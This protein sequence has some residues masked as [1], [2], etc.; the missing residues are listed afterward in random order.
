MFLPERLAHTV[1]GVA[2][3]LGASSIQY[4]AANLEKA[5]AASSAAHEMELLCASL[6]TSIAQLLA[7]LKPLLPS[8]EDAPLQTAEWPQLDSVI[9]QLSR[10][11]A[12]SDSRAV[13]YFESVAPQLRS[14]FAEGKFESLAAL[15]ENYSFPEALDQLVAANESSKERLRR[16]S[17]HEL[18]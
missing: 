3:N 2:G 10:Y 6:D 4:A 7:G 5:I 1:K 14:Y 12:E 11:L 15:I 13:E 16:T 18:R 8:A 9:E 17:G